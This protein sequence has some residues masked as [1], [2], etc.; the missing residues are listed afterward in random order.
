[1]SFFAT[2][3]KSSHWRTWQALQQITDAFKI[4]GE[5]HDKVLEHVHQ[6]VPEYVASLFASHQELHQMFGRICLHNVRRLLFDQEHMLHLVPLTEAVLR[7]YEL[8]AAYEAGQI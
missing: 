4:L 1:M 6:L 5:V 2:K 8:R 3:G 7:N